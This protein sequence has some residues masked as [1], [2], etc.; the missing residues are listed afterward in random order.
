MRKYMFVGFVFIVRV[1]TTLLPNMGVIQIQEDE[2]KWIGLYCKKKKYTYI[3]FLK[4]CCTSKDD[5]ILSFQ[6]HGIQCFLL[7]CCVYVLWGEEFCTENLCVTLF[8]FIE[9]HV[10]DL[11]NTFFMLLSLHICENLC[12]TKGRTEV[13][14]SKLS[15]KDPIVFYLWRH[16]PNVSEAALTTFTSRLI[17]MVGKLVKLISVVIF[18]YP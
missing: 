8:H 12:K 4:W 16:R 18:Y 3:F 1:K 15:K 7:R 13:N 6:Q 5:N 9:R 2:W 17:W 10:A 14:M 11:K